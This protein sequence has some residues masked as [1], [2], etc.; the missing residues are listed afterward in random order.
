MTTDTRE[1]LKRQF[2]GDLRV[3]F[4]DDRCPTKPELWLI[5]Q[6]ATVLAANFETYA[7]IANGR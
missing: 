5:E 2:A 6:A 3:F 7:K 4:A 1:A